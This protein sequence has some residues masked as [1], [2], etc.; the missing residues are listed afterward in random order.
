M[1]NMDI[2]IYLNVIGGFIWN[3]DK[4]KLTQCLDTQ[5]MEENPI[6]SYNE[7]TKSEE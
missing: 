4:T 3:Q 1:M 6:G 7:Y 2:S 5:G